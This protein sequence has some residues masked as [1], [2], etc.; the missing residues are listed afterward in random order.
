MRNHNLR[1]SISIGELEHHR[2][3]V[4]AMTGHAEPDAG[5]ELFR[6]LERARVL[7]ERK[8]PPD[9][10]RMG[11]NV[12]YRTDAGEQRSVTLVYPGQA[13]ISTG[14][15]SVLT[16]VGTALIGLRVGQSIT[17]LTR[18]AKNNV[19]TLLSVQQPGGEWMH[20][21]SASSG[22]SL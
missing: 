20:A 5:D 15:V 7:P 22:A 19:L 6:E 10:V 12:I 14:K 16:P 2:L 17:W 1:P 11:S 3:L 18:G 9:V 21:S 4:L 13:D 8:L